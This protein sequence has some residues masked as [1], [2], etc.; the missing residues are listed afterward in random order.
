MKLY[1]KRTFSAAHFLPNYEGDCKSMHGHSWLTEVWLEGEVNP[2]TG[3]LADFKQVKNIL[4]ELDHCCLNDTFENP[5]AENLVLYLY[6]NI[7]NCTKVR[8]WESEDCYAE[9]GYVRD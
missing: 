4:D 3:M 6:T 5:T 1:V 2:K 8:L 9:V 7:P